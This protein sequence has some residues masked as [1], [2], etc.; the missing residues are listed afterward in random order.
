MKVLLLLDP[1]DR[2][3]QT[4]NFYIQLFS[5]ISNWINSK[6]FY[7]DLEYEGDY[8]I[9]VFN[10][11]INENYQK[12]FKKEL[13]SYGNFDLI[14]T[15]SPNPIV[16]EVFEYVLNLSI[17][18]YSRPPFP[19]YYQLDPWGLLWKSFT[20]NAPRF[21]LCNYENSEKL[22]QKINFIETKEKIN[23]FPFN[24]EYWFLKVQKLKK[25]QVEYFY[26]FDKNF[27]TVFWTQKPSFNF[28]ND[29]HE[30]NYDYLQ[31]LPKN[32]KI[33]QNSSFI[34][35]SCNKIWATHSTLGFQAAL[36]N[37]EI[38]S[39][40]CFYYWKGNQSGTIGALL[41]LVWFNDKYSFY[42]R[43][44]K[45]KIYK[46]CPKNLSLSFDT[47]ENYINHDTNFYRL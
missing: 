23:L 4:R 38:V 46:K 26:E 22:K 18:I 17:G 39:P 29:K 42:D 32:K 43:I 12:Q 37:V 19:I 21:N 24:S 47:I 34:I 40:S 35:P 28:L 14:I 16:R 36:W 7:S 44:E 9:D 15:N 13:E 1:G 2:N 41:D 3:D 30:F 10:N 6:F 25:S 33:E 45:L 8:Y 31:I 11:T 5:K 20:Y 27:E